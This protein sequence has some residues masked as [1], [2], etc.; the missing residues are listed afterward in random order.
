[1][2]EYEWGRQWC[3]SFASTSFDQV[4]ADGMAFATAACHVCKQRA[5]QRSQLTVVQYLNAAAHA[6]RCSHV[7][8]NLHTS[9]NLKCHYGTS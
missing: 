9:A 1:M 5:S 7:A 4:S 8:R 3:A 6:V 2:Q